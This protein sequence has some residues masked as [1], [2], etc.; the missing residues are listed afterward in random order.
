MRDM[1]GENSSA[2][3]P[4]CA[5]FPSLRLLRSRARTAFRERDPKLDISHFY[6]GTCTGV[7]NLRQVLRGGSFAPPIFET[8]RSAQ[9]AASPEDGISHRTAPL[10]VRSA[11]RL[12]RPSLPPY[13]RRTG[14]YAP[15][16]GRGQAPARPRTR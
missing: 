5:S 4:R 9:A 14:G 1:A 16:G 6:V 2:A 10:A 15:R 7:A 12:L 8:G 3:S 11:R 13:P